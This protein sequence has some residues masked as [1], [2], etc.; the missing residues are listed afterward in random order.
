VAERW[1]KIVLGALLALVALALLQLR[2]PE[3]AERPKGDGYLLRGFRLGWTL[4]SQRVSILRFGVDPESG[5]IGF[6]LGAGRWRTFDRAEGEVRMTAARGLRIVHAGE[7]P[8]DGGTRE[9]VIDLHRYHLIFD[10]VAVA[11]T[12]FEVDTAAANVDTGVSP[13]LI[14]GGIE[15]VSRQGSVLRVNVRGALVAGIVERD[16]PRV[17]NFWPTVGLAL[18]ALPRGAER[19]PG[20]LERQY[21]TTRSP[22]QASVGFTT[23]PGP[24]AAVPLLRGFTWELAE[25]GKGCPVR[26]VDIDLDVERDPA[27]GAGSVLISERFSNR[28]A[29]GLFAE[30]LR[31]RSRV[32]WSVLFLPE[33][34]APARGYRSGRADVR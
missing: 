21:F 20:K 6:G 12:S 22:A 13:A 7:Y 1:K 11:L 24:G 19:I 23:T 16:A 34:R 3:S 4:G 29:A 17:T 31:V 5:E 30:K 15:S 25:S 33:G 8:I 26:E 14:E 18:I 28:G 9:I 2:I 32:D 27:R 10:E